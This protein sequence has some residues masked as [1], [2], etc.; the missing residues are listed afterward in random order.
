MFR[1]YLS[2]SFAKLLFVMFTKNKF[3]YRSIFFN[4]E[5]NLWHCSI[6]KSCLRISC[7]ENFENV[8]GKHGVDQQIHQRLNVLQRCFPEN[9]FRFS[10]GQFSCLCLDK[11]V[12]DT[13]MHF[14]AIIL[15]QFFNLIFCHMKDLQDFQCT[16][17]EV[18]H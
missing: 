14:P 10:S 8:S 3:H 1:L 5:L 4:Q 12:W 16:K 6:I 11:T 15:Y 2:L 17:N 13:E 18:F 7:P 9:F